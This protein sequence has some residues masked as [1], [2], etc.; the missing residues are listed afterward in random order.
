[1]TA[2]SV[3]AP[4]AANPPTYHLVGTFGGGQIRLFVDGQSNG[5]TSAS[6]QP[7]SGSFIV[8]GQRK[9]AD[10]DIDDASV[11]ATALS[12][13]QVR[14]HHELGRG[15]PFPVSGQQELRATAAAAPGRSVREVQFLVDE[16]LVGRDDTPPYSVTWDTAA[17]AVPD[18]RH[19]VTARVVDDH[20]RE[21]ATA[22]VAVQVTNVTSGTPRAQLTAATAL[23]DTLVHGSGHPGVAVGVRVKNT[24]DT[25]IANGSAVLRYRWQRPDGTFDDSVAS[26]VSLGGDLAPGAERTLNVTVEPSALPQGMSRSRMTLRFD[27]R[28]TASPYTWWAAR[29]NAP[30]EHSVLI[31]RSAEVGLGL[32]RYYHYDGE[33]LAAACRSSS[34][35]RRATTSSASRRS[36][37]PAEGCRPSST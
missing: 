34:T 28:D 1:M 14:A 25:T 31:Q 21:S 5:S 17:G 33:E 12:A 20:D 8:L 10:L 2:S 29:G 26:N 3:I 11:Y 15:R 9:G 32:E 13:Q 37:R 30:L 35:S 7:S 22:P 19:E 36:R 18:G 23:P 16:V 6:L 4:S 27:L 24:G